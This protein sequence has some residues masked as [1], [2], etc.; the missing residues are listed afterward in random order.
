MTST[1]F[2]PAS[3]YSNDTTPITLSDPV[4][5]D[6]GTGY[7]I[8]TDNKHL[9]LIFPNVVV[10][11]SLTKD[12]KLVLI[13]SQSDELMTTLNSVRS[14]LMTEKG[15]P[16]NKMKPILSSGKNLQKDIQTFFLNPTHTA[17]LKDLQKR[18]V[19]Y[20]SLLK[21]TC[22]MHLFVQIQ[23]LF[24]NDDGRYSLV[25]KATQMTLLELPKEE[26]VIEECTF[27]VADLL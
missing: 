17:I 12:N 19:S 9:V 26:E 4:K 15:I 5:R 11:P 1:S 14:R 3:K 20:K 23:S 25:L 13:V 6:Y 2:I 8:T 27:D 16:E 18:D 10:K 22:K 21:K 24:L 7:S